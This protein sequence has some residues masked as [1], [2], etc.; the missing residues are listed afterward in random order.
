MKTAGLYQVFVD[1]L[2]LGKLGR[3]EFSVDHTSKTLTIMRVPTRL[4]KKIW[5]LRVASPPTEYRII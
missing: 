3:T 4:V 5:S 1:A 2:K